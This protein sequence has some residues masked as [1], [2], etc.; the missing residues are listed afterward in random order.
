MSFD[1]IELECLDQVS[2]L[3]LNDPGVLN[4][5]TTQMIEELDRALDIA[6]SQSRVIILTG[7]GR[8][9]CAGADLNAGLGDDDFG[10]V[11]ETH[12]NPLMT[13][14]R[15]LPT[16]WI[17]SVRGP[18]AGVGCSFALAADLVIASETAYFLQAFVR[19]GIVPDGGSSHLLMRGLSRVRAMEMMMLGDKI[20]ARQ[21]LEWGLINRVVA[22]DAL[23]QTAMEFAAR[24]ANGPTRAYGLIRRLAWSAL[25]S[26]WEA[27][28]GLE[29]EL[30]KVAGRTQDAGEGVAAFLAKRS[31]NFFG[32]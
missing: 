16:P 4:A 29:R 28:L 22:D 27:A 9:F 1:K 26:T 13:K 31:A 30:Q 23:D 15:G 5:V 3:R 20:P 7:A 32:C 18:A 10:L 8:A 19:I 24:L 12:I 6:I 11:L 2:I 17:A 25:D 14:L 21:A